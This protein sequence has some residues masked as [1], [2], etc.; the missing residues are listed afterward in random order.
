[1]KSSKR[2]MAVLLCMLAAVTLLTP[3][4]R[5]AGTIDINQDVHMGISYRDQGTPLVGAWVDIYLVATIDD[6]GELKVTDDFAPYNVVINP[7]KETAWKRLASTLEGIVLRD[8]LTPAD[9]GAT[10]AQGLLSFPNQRETLERGLYLVLGRSHTQNERLYESTPFVVTLPH[11]EELPG[12][13]TAWSYDVD[14]S[15]KFTSRW[16]SSHT[17]TKITRKVLK[18]WEDDGNEEERPKEI[19]VQLLQDGRVYDTVTLNEENN[20]RYTWTELSRDSIWTVVEADSG[21]YTVMVER[22]GITFVVTNTYPEEIPDPPPPQGGPPPEESSPPPPEE[23]IPP[24]KTPGGRVP[25][26]GQLWWP[27]PV[28]TSA[29]LLFI[30]FGL[31]RRR[32]SGS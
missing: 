18:V 16:E 11:L 10:D 13:G 12:G 5:A 29:G 7:Q 8:G 28:L 25:Q 6:Q 17:S 31:L 27:V 20:W 22:E 24:G 9:S 21:D 15:M 14:V 1:M 30:I 3:S 19:T 23:D 4:A 32:G 2:V 26:T